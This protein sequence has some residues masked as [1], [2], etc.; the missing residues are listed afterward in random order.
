LKKPQNTYK[1]AYRGAHINYS[2]AVESLI[3]YCWLPCNSCVCTVLF[4]Q[5]L[6]I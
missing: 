3:Q 1:N 6:H 5:I 4:D 2:K